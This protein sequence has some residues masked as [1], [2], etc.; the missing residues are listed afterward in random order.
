MRSLFIYPA[1]EQTSSN[2]IPPRSHLYHLAPVG[3]GSALVESL[4]SYVARLADAHDVSI[5]TLVTREVL[6]KVR[7]EF[8]RHE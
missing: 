7:E 5:G 2:S 8:R 1:W 3:M 4:T 6:P